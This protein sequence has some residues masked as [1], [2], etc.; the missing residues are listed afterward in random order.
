[1]NIFFTVSGRSISSILVPANENC[2]SEITPYGI[3][4]FFIFALYSLSFFHVASKLLIVVMFKFLVPSDSTF[5]TITSLLFI[6][7]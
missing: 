7:E 1:M 4:T 5:G 6:V 2:C 3:Y